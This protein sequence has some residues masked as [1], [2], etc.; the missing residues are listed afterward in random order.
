[1][2]WFIVVLLSVHCACA[3]Q[4]LPSPGATPS[5]TIS[6]SGDS[7]LR[8]G[9]KYRIVSAGIHYFR[10]PSAEWAQRLDTIAASGVNTITT[11]IPWN[12][13][14]P[15]NKD[16]CHF[17]GDRNVSHFL[18]LASDRNLLVVIRPGPYICAEWEFGGYP[19]WLLSMGLGMELR[20]YN[21]TV[22]A[23][24]HDWFSLLFREARIIDRLYSNGGPIVLIQVENEYGQYPSGAPDKLYLR[25][26]RDL[27]QTLLNNASV[28]YYSTDPNRPQNIINSAIEG[29]FQAI[30]FFYWDTTPHDVPA[31][32]RNQRLG[33]DGGLSRKGPS[34]NGEMYPGWLTQWGDPVVKTHTVDYVVNLTT[35]ALLTYSGNYTSS[36]NF[37]M[38]FGGTNFGFWAGELCT[39]SYDYGAPINESGHATPMYEALRSLISSLPHVHGPRS[40]FTQPPPLSDYGRVLFDDNSYRSLPDAI[41]FVSDTVSSH[42]GSHQ[43][44]MEDVGQYYGL[45]AYSVA[46]PATS[47]VV[48][49]GMMCRDHCRVYGSNGNQEVAYIGSFEGSEG[50][51]FTQPSSPFDKVTIVV[52]NVGRKNFWIESQLTPTLFNKGIVGS[53]T[54]NGVIAV[55]STVN[56]MPMDW[57]HVSRVWAS[58]RQLLVGC[59]CFHRGS[60]LVNGPTSAS[61]GTILDMRAWQKGIVFVNGNTLGR[62]WTTS[63]PQRSLFVPPS[64]IKQG[65]N[66]IVIFEEG[67]CLSL[68]A[69]PLFA[70]SKNFNIY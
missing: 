15:T 46:V 49:L 57:E 51:N 32:W 29:V 7:F 22:L 28:V 23:L 39:T 41:P 33:M 6:E 13:H 47:S 68:E 3:L 35:S 50:I 10:V 69:P 70:T 21:P 62:Y 58:P 40:A 12:F 53:I 14:C 1:M 37:Y 27:L 34:Y 19:A 38:F 36:S 2:N 52:S 9:S 65:H 63:S 8:D 31:A 11:Y 44:T 25:T 20:R 18:Q 54:V 66:D 16:I 48:A 59:G 56:A 17:D 26:L 61:G 30:D 42:S 43:P 4:G 55:S 24:V 45:I 67:T 64:F 60:L 5:F